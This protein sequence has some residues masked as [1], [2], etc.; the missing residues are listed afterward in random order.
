MTDQPPVPAPPRSW[1]ATVWGVVVT[2]AIGGYIAATVM[3]WDFRT[4]ERETVP[5]TVRSSPGGYRT[6]HFW[7]VGYHGGK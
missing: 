2:V 3:G 6:F 5:P 1:L 7:H 4:T